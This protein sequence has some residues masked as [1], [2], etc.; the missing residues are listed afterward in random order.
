M[1][2]HVREVGPVTVLDLTGKLT[3]DKGGAGLLDAIDGLL[4]CGTRAILI[5]LDQVPYMD[6]A[7]I[8]ALVSSY[9]R[10]LDRGA[11]VKLLN[12]K[13]RVFDLLHLVKL[14]AIFECFHEEQQAIASFATG[15]AP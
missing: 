9:K 3:L 6:S 1:E 13:K 8:G 14:D 12:P 10:A 11:T 15:Q 5:N 4:H 2:I 7:G